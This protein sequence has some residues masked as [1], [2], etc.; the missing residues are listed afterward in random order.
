MKNQQPFELEVRLA[1]SAPIIR[2]SNS[3]IRRAFGDPGTTET[4]EF[5]KYAYIYLVWSEDGTVEKT[6]VETF[7]RVELDEDLWVRDENELVYSVTGDPVYLYTQKMVSVISKKRKWG[8]LYVAVSKEDIAPYVKGT[9]P[10]DTEP[11]SLTEVLNL[12]FDNNTSA[13]QASLQNIYSTPYNYNVE[14]KYY[15]EVVNFT[16]DES[17]GTGGKVAYANLL[18]YHVAAKV[19]LMWNVTEAKRDS[20]KVSYVAATNLY[21]GP[22][23][24]FMPTENEI[25]NYATYS[26]AGHDGYTEVLLN[27][28]SPCPGTQWNGRAYFYA[29]PYKNNDVDDESGDPDPHYPLQLRL[30]KGGDSPT[31][32]NYYWSVVKTEVPAVWTSWIRGQITINNGKYNVTAP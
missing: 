32:G 1:V 6:H 9:L 25:G 12:V 21:D 20:V 15:G 29:I 24:V 4:L 10:H 13:V 28:A 26:A 27:E 23:Y 14:E 19:D 16:Y 11:E 17:A 31:G 8:K 18:L 2:T 5:P 3:P 30:Q 7:P 22:C